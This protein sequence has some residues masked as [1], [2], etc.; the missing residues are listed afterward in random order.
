[1][2]RATS[3]T[4]DA[5]APTELATLVARPEFVRAFAWIDGALESLTR[6]H[7]ELNEIEAPPFLESVRAE[8][9][10][11]AF[12]EAGLA[13]VAIDEV[14]NV[15]AT[16]SGY[17]DGPAVVLSAHI[18]TVFPAGTDCRVRREGG[19]LLAPG[20][21]D[22]GCGLMAMLAVAR[23]L[24]AGGIRTRRPIRFLASVGEEGDGDLRGCRH[25]FAAPD[26]ASRVA[27]FVSLDGPG[28][29]RVTHRA[30]G[31]RRFEVTLTG[32]GGH[33]WGDFGIVNPIHAIGRAISTMSTYP[34]PLEPR[35]SYSVGIV[36]GGTSVNAI[37]AVAKCRVD[38][39][40]VAAQELDRAELFFRDAVANAVAEENRIAAASGTVLEVVVRPIGD[41]PSGETPVEAPI[42]QLAVDASHELGIRPVLDCASTDSNIP[43]SLG[44]PAVTLGGGGSGGSTHT[45][46]EWYDPAGRDLGIKRA[47]LL[48]A[49]LAGV[50][51]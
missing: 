21:A 42:V 29:E 49:A 35:T 46:D 48:M 34:V 24:D 3:S 44:I 1:M 17:E 14:G 4:P 30:L 7:I 20:I 22:D 10:R 32:P 51:D 50:A 41:R 6:E 11:R 16:R 43:I 15:V 19:R 26:A 5:S 12:E 33:S 36:S 31:S 37:P 25:F 23:A 28:T 18:D 8:W 47:L 45:L 9:L 39:R 40:S 13:D 2:P 38:L 27:A